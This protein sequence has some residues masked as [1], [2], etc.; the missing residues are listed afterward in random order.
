MRFTSQTSR[1]KVFRPAPSASQASSVN[2][3]LSM[4]V[5][6]SRRI[7]WTLTGPTGK[8]VGRER[9]SISS[10]TVRAG[11][12]RRARTSRPEIV[13]IAA[14]LVDAVADGRAVGIAVLVERLEVRD[15]AVP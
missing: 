5:T 3:P 8:G 4:S 11:A 9:V 2:G 7:T 10:F 12:P 13:R 15:H 14:R 6:G 1:P